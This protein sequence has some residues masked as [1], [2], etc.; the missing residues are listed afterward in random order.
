VNEIDIDKNLTCV[1]SVF[2][3]PWWL[4]AVAQG[5][6][7]SIEINSGGKTTARL[8]YVLYKRFGFKI[9]GMPPNT[10]TLGIYFEDTGAKLSN[11]LGRQKDL[12]F[13]IIDQLPER[14]NV[15]IA[16]DHRCLYVM[17]FIWKGF[18]IQPCFSY[19]IENLNDL[20]EIWNGFRA[21]IRTDIRK[22]EKILHI[23]DDLSINALIKMQRKTFQRQGRSI[24]GHSEILIQLDKAARTHDARKLI[25]AVDGDGNIHAAG[26]FVYDE[27]N[28][29]YLIGG[30]DPEFR[31]SGAGSL[32]LWEGIKFASTVSEAFDFE[33]SMIEDIERFFRAF[34]GKPTVYYRVTKLNPLLSLL[35]YMKPRIKKIIGY[36]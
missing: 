36:K 28:C 19:R 30:G 32:V 14:C 12:I 23:C 2:E 25:C 29:Y 10:Q 26:Y 21:N 27:R 8:P 9:I 1:N 17:P 3:Q 13:A 34:G 33:G 11:K 20:D 5:R 4:D 31:N 24:K 15:D 16:L 35:D 7:Q 18:K 6:W 22:A